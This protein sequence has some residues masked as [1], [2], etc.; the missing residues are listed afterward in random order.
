MSAPNSILQSRTTLPVVT[1][2]ERPFGAVRYRCPESG[3]F[4]LLTDPEALKDSF[5]RPI[6]CVGCGGLHRLRQADTVA[7]A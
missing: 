4:V 6:R 5:M 2:I 7:A 3:S 1:A